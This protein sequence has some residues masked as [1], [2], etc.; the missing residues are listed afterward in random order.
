MSTQ[1]NLF[2]FIPALILF[3]LISISLIR[4][5]LLQ[6]AVQRRSKKPQVVHITNSKVVFAAD[7]YAAAI[8][9]VK[10]GKEAQQKKEGGVLKPE[11]H[12]RR[13]AD[14]NKLSLFVDF[15]KQGRLYKS[16]SRDYSK[17]GMFIKTKR[18]DQFRIDDAITVTFKEPGEI[19]RKNEGRIVRKTN[20]GMGVQF[21]AV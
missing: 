12:E 14:R 17:T 2:I 7:K 5:V 11:G 1:M 19:H 6:N 15:V 18:P 16:I 4:R 9:D 8:D 13:Q 21:S 3:L 20:N 10:P